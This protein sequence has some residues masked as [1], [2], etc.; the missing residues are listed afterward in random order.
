MTKSVWKIANHQNPGPLPWLK[1]S[2]KVGS[3]KYFFTFDTLQEKTQ[4]H[5][6][7]G[8]VGLKFLTKR[9]QIDGV[10]IKR[11]HSLNDKKYKK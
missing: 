5:I 11:I 2:F 6:L 10:M 1:N 8:D 9:I 4:I 3:T 7:R